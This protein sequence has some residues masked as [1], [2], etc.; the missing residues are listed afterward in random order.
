M[1]DSLRGTSIIIFSVNEIAF[2][3]LMMLT[4]VQ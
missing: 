1:N 3:K 4:D 2:W